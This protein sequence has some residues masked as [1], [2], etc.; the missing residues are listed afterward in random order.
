MTREAAGNKAT[1]ASYA[2][3]DDAPRSGPLRTLVQFFAIP[4]LIVSVAI[5]IYVG[6]WSLVGGGPRSLAD[7]AR[8]M[9]SDTINRRWQAAMEVSRRIREAV[10]RDDREVLQE[11][12]EEG[13]VRTLLAVLQTARRE[14]PRLEAQ[15]AATQILLVLSLIDS[16][17]ALEA[18]RDAARDTDGWI[19]VHAVS[20]LGRLQ[21]ADS[22]ALFVEYASHHDHGTRQ[23]ALVALAGLDHRP[24]RPLVLTSATREVAARH[25]QDA[26]P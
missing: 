5:G 6:I 17:V 19:R 1:P 25:L 24:G 10:D 7:Y 9:S 16:P 3:F 14:A 15:V 2:D 13:F 26:H 11:A 20:A 4:L 8:L 22:R 18:V 12:R 21:D 23:A